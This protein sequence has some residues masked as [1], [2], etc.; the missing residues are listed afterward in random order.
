MDEGV[1]K[2]VEM[3]RYIKSFSKKDFGN[4]FIQNRCFYLLDKDIRNVMDF[5]KN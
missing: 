2:V 3:K 5:Y 4:I 1:I